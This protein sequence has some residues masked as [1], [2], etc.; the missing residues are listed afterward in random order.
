[1][2]MPPLLVATI[3]ATC[4]QF[5]QHFTGSFCVNILAKKKLQIQTETQEKLRKTLSYKKVQ[6]KC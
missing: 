5:H 3:T 4:S 1:M 2:R 6:V